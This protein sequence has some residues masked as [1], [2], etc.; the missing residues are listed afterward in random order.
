MLPALAVG[1][2]VSLA[3]LVR[4]QEP[5]PPPQPHDQAAPSDFSQPGVEVQARGPVHEAY[6]EPTVRGPRPSPV[7]PKQPP[8]PIEEMPPDQKPAGDNVQWIPGYWS[9]DEDRS[10][11]LWVSGIWRDVPPNEQWVPGHWDQVDTGWQW[12]P[13]YWANTEQ[14]QVEYLPEPPDPIQEAIAT[15]PAPDDVFVPGCWVYREARYLWRPGFWI[16]PRPGWLWTPAHYVWSPAGYVFVD[17]FWDYP[18]ESRGLLFAPVLIA[19]DVIARANWFFRPREVVSLP[20]LLTSL[21]V[22]PVNCHYYFGDYFDPGYERAGFISWVD[23]RLGRTFP[24]N[25]L[26]YYRWR[27]RDNPRW[28]N[29]LHQFYVARREGSAP[30]PPRTVVVQNTQVQNTTVVNNITNISNLTNINQI[31]NIT[32][33]SALNRLNPTTNKLRPL[34]KNEV[35]TERKT[36]QQFHTVARER[37][38]V[39]TQARAQG[40]TTG[41]PL[42]VDMP[43]TR[44]AVQHPAGQARQV[45]ARPAVPE[46][47]VHRPAPGTDETRPPVR[48]ETTRPREEPGRPR[49]ERPTAEPR[50]APR[51]PETQPRPERRPEPPRPEERRPQPESRPAPRPPEHKPAAPEP[52]PAPRPPESHPA[53]EHR[54]APAPRPPEHKP[55]APEHKPP[56]PEH[57]P[58]APPPHNPPKPPEHP[59]PHQ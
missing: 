38:R 9:W 55:P 4:T 27:F 29:D 52:R 30:R 25:L 12:A 22:R 13:G 34:T 41:A 23:F 49:P 53:P 14:T 1:V 10:D 42:R 59:N 37:A 16:T 45:P 20:F 11:F 21:F 31:R 19:Q 26:S 58:P 7:V 40:H 46:P 33:V 48:P 44:P 56:A 50:P 15:P 6:A 32:P 57:K 3:G 17:G 43:K 2:W 24:D 36:V 47:Q 18:L 8:D 28:V 51:P 5:P 54:P 39:E 35:A